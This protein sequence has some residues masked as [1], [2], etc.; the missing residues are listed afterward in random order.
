MTLVELIKSP[1]GTT[2]FCVERRERT[3]GR[4]ELD[5]AGVHHERIRGGIRPTVFFAATAESA[6]AQVEQYDNQRKEKYK[7]WRESASTKRRNATS[8]A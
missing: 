5:Y 1:I 7:K 8:R 3:I 2:R 4:P 6:L